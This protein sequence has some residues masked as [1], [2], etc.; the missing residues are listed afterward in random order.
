MDVFTAIIAAMAA[1]LPI[2]PEAKEAPVAAVPQ[3]V[4]TIRADNDLCGLSHDY[5]TPNGL[6]TI[7]FTPTPTQDDLEVV[8]LGP[9][10]GMSAASSGHATMI[11]SPSGRV[12]V[13]SFRSFLLP[14]PGKQRATIIRADR[15]IFDGLPAATELRIE[16][17]SFVVYPLRNTNGAVFAL[18]DCEQSLMRKWGIDMAEFAKAK[19]P[20]KGLNPAGWFS[21]DDY[22]TTAL[23]SGVGGRTVMLVGVSETGKVLSCRPVI[24]SRNID[25]DQA[26]CRIVKNRGKF[27]P[28]SDATGH[29]LASWAILAVRWLR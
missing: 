12:V 9:A 27:Q 18:K 10:R 19:I 25:L 1:I 24:S 8:T 3:G 29:G 22:P 11:L 20:P 13:G 4:W 5:S 2:A 14:G 16:A 17:N 23:R 21:S 26:S 6:V 28:A 15:A 7:G